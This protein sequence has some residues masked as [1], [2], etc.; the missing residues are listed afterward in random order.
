LDQLAKGSE[1][2][3]QLVVVAGHATFELIELGGELSVRRRE[4]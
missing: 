4:I 2:R 3:V 1:N